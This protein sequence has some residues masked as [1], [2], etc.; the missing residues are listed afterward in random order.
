MQALILLQMLCIGKAA[1]HTY[2]RQVFFSLTN[3]TSQNFGEWRGVWFLGIC[4]NT[5][6]M[7][8]MN[9]C[10]H[11]KI[12][13]SILRTNFILLLGMPQ[14]FWKL[15]SDRVPSRSS[16]FER[17]PVLWSVS[18]FLI[19]AQ[20]GVRLS[21]R[22]WPEINITNQRREVSAFT[23]NPFPICLVSALYSVIYFSKISP[24]PQIRKLPYPIILALLLLLV[25]FLPLS[26]LFFLVRPP[27]A[28]LEQFWEKGE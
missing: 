27:E 3:R 2:F 23:K 25:P 28:T 16:L 13:M 4:N 15:L 7:F 14:E 24:T 11:F 20:Q 18:N 22:W 19:K 21:S 5:C 10:F 9:I 26:M 8:T 17:T 12:H 1:V 6:H